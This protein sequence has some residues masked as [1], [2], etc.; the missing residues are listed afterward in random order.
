MPVHFL[1]E[2]KFN[3]TKKDKDAFLKVKIRKS[4]KI[5]SILRFNQS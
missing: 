4:S 2:R 3:Q 1:L 5:S